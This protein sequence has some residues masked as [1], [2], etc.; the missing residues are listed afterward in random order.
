[1]QNAKNCNKGRENS[2]RWSWRN[3]LGDTL[4]GELNCLPGPQTLV[5]GAEGTGRATHRNIDQSFKAVTNPRGPTMCQAFFFDPKVDNY[6]QS[7]K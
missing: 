5:S 1:M 4:G 2:W 3:I 6:S 7:Y